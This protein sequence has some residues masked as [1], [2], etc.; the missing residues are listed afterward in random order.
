MSDTHDEA[1]Q[2]PSIH[3][4]NSEESQSANVFINNY[5]N[6]YHWKKVHANIIAMRA[7]IKLIEWD[8]SSLSHKW[9]KRK[10][11]SFIHEH[12]YKCKNFQV[13][14][15]SFLSFSSVH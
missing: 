1:L 11:N 3:K 14:V 9:T 7:G 6:G 2:L 13:W 4:L 5:L 15:Y 10:K 8:R 12:T